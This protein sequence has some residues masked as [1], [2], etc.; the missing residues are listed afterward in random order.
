M[1]SLPNIKWQLKSATSQISCKISEKAEHTLWKHDAWCRYINYDEIQGFA[2][3]FY[4]P[5]NFLIDC[6]RWWIFQPY[7][8]RLHQSL[9][10]HRNSRLTFS[11]NVLTILDKFKC[12]GHFPN[13]NGKIYSAKS[14]SSGCIKW[15]CVFSETACLMQQEHIV[16]NESLT[17]YYES[18][19]AFRIQFLEYVM[20]TDSHNSKVF[21]SWLKNCH[22]NDRN[23]NLFV[24]NIFNCSRWAAQCEWVLLVISGHLFDCAELL[25]PKMFNYCLITVLFKLID[26]MHLNFIT[27]S[28]EQ[29]F[30]MIEKILLNL[31]I[32]E[33]KV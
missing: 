32:K 3:F 5:N 7:K 6:S 14:Y 30:I 16:W 15:I 13:C 25:W 12:F 29:V 1:S 21:L 31:R 18:S 19:H 23:L 2:H 17:K 10:V 11:N 22:F 24:V 26:W 20:W 28:H 8:T 33:I 9:Y 27:A 4:L